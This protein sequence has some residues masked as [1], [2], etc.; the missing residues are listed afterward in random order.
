MKKPKRLRKGDR[1]AVLSPSWGGPSIC[2][3]IYEKGLE[4]LRL[5]GLQPVE[6]PTARM[7]AQELYEYPEIRARDIN[8]AFG[9]PAVKGII[10][11]I[12]GSDSVRILK[13]LDRDL[14]RKNPK[15][16]MGYS[17]FTSPS[18][19]VHQTGLVTFNGPAVM[20]GFSQLQS[21]TGE[22]RAY[23]ESYLFDPRET[24]VLPQFPAYSDGYPPWS[25]VKNTGLVNPLK[26]SDG[27][28]FIQ[29]EGIHEGVM[30]GGCIE[31]LEMLK[32]TEY[33]PAPD[34][35][36]GKILFLETSEDKPPVDYIRYWLRNYGVMGVFDRIAGI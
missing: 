2:P 7:A 24:L 30:F 14:I 3:H 23:L 31:V 12:G 33:W 36:E 10:S 18:T 34:F 25:D 27:L 19:W 26:P 1:V 8:R 5:F 11:T 35:W 16:F 6:Y 20:A 29:G 22:Y 17:D 21:F 9:D 15:L 32:G 13:F 4:N 28:H